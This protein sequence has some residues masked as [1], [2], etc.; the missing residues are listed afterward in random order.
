M[1]SSSVKTG[2]EISIAGITAK[3]LAKEFGTPAF[4]IDQ[5]DFYARATEWNTALKDSLRAVFQAVARE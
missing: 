1:W 4:F 3:D 5:A 2:A